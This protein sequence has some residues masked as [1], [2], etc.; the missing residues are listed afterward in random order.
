MRWGSYHLS[1]TLD[2][3]QIG[4]IQSI[5]EVIKAEP[6]LGP[7]EAPQRNPLFAKC[8]SDEETEEKQLYC[9]KRKIF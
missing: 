2:R 5:W 9:L 6:G 4:A 7:T 3:S 8:S 1:N